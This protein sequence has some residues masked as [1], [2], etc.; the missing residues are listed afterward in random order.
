MKRF[1]QGLIVALGLTVVSVPAVVSAAPVDVFQGCS[2]TN[3]TVCNNSD[4]K[5]QIFG[6]G[7]IFSRIISTLFIVIGLI[8]VIIIVIGGLRYVLS[9][10]DQNAVN[11]AKNTI[12]YAVIGLVISI[13]AY[14]IVNFV[15]GN[16]I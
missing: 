14:A 4:A 11:S 13:L 16:V 8:A 2:G 5:S 12:L 7:G 10:G 6:S 15:I 9:A 3:S 1:L